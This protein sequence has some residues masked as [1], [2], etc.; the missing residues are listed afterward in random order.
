MLVTALRLERRQLCTK[1]KKFNICKSSAV[2]RSTP[3]KW[4][5]GSRSLWVNGAKTWLNV[6]V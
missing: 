3:P 2:A 1:K 6:R 5:P 4:L